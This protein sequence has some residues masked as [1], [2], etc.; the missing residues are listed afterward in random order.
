MNSP[1]SRPMASHTA[2]A[3]A[4]PSLV[5]DQVASP[6]NSLYD[7]HWIDLASCLGKEVR[8]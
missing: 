8:K 2:S 5:T 4:D 1:Q 3:P 6:G 7:R